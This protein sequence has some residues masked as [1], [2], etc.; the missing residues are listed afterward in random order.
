MLKAQKYSSDKSGLG[1]DKIVVSN[2]ASSS[3]TVFVKPEVA[4]PQNSCED[5][6]N[7]LVISCENANI[8]PAMPIMKHSKSRSP[9]TGADHMYAGGKNVPPKVLKFPLKFV[10]L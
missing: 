4:E 10:N 6:G 1:F 8:K 9:P 3:K 2:I 5:K 7:A